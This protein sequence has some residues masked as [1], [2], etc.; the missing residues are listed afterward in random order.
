[1]HAARR[2][3]LLT[4]IIP[5][6]FA[7]L[8]STGFIGARFGLPHIEPFFLL[9]IRYAIVI[10]LFALALPFLRGGPVR[11]RALAWQA[12]IGALLHGIYLGGVFLAISRGAPPGLVSIIVGFQP[13]LTAAVGVAFLGEEV[14]SRQRAGLVLGAGGVT[15]VILGAQGVGAGS[16]LGMSATLV[17][18]AGITAG[19]VLQK[20]VGGGAAL[21]PGM[22]AQYAGALAVTLPL[23]L[24][25]ET[26]EADLTWTLV[27][28]IAWLVLGLSVAAIALLMVMIRAEQVSKV[29][30]YFYLVPPLTVLQSWLFFGE[31]LPPVSALG[32]LMAVAGVYLATRPPRG[33]G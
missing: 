9:A 21:L 10:A 5:L 28:T 8:W 19:T 22:L 18:L 15:L 3:T 7:L 20:K 23:T 30:S 1:M 31:T 27:L 13:I 32:G 4:R 2:P 33:K 11:P 12:V 25:L 17:A 6:A 14:G 16:A 24:A 29:S 26:R